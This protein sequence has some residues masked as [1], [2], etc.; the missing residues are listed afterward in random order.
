[1]GVR[2]YLIEG[3]SGSGKTAV[4]TELLR[5]GYEAIHG[6]RVLAY[7]GD[8]ET[9]APLTD[10]EVTA[11]G[12]FAGRHGAG[13]DCLEC[14]AWA[15]RFWV[16]K[17][18]RVQ[19]MIADH[20]QSVTFFCGGSRNVTKIN[21][22]FDGVYVLDVDLE[23]LLSRLARRPEDEFG[24]KQSE[25]DLVALRHRTRAAR[26]R[27]LRVPEDAIVVDTRRPLTEVVDEI[28]RRS[29]SRVTS[30]TA[31]GPAGGR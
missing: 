30:A 19:A 15:D 4:C 23:T 17:L 13:C 5:R 11:R 9:G 12:P 6:D 7:Q 20:R 1:M 24:G 21:S 10:A 29:A 27:D 31:I 26:L 3:V 25:R 16:W 18:D 28:I 22:R 2:N 14:L 8:P